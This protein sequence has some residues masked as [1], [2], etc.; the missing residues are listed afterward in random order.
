MTETIE[1][2]PGAACP[3]EEQAVSLTSDWSAGIP[4]IFAVGSM[5][6]KKGNRKIRILKR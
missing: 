3:E 1:H 4:K 5:I 2:G 6:Q